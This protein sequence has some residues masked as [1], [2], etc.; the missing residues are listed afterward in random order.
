MGMGYIGAIEKIKFPNSDPY[1]PRSG[2][3][4]P[5]DQRGK[6]LSGCK[7]TPIASLAIEIQPENLQTLFKFAFILKFAK[8]IFQS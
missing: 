8:N 3:A 5:D 7:L 2:Y 1:A 6:A 4:E